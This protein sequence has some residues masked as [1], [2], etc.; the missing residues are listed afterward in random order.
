MREAPPFSK[1]FYP[2]SIAV[3]GVSPEGAN[4]ARNIVL[5]T[6]TCGFKGEVFSV[7]RTQ[8]V[9]FGQKI[10]SSVEEIDREIDLAVILT[11]A[12]TIPGI[13]EQ[14]GRKGIKAAV[15]E[16]GGF[17]EFDAEGKALEQACTAAAEKYGIR[18]VGPNGIGVTNLESGLAL[19]FMPLRRDLCLGPV[20]ILAQ[21]GGVGLSYVN[22]LSDERIGFNKFVSM[23]NKRNINENELMEYLIHDPGTK[24]ILI[25]LEGFSDGRKFVEV[26]SRSE[27][28]ILVHKSNRFETSAQIAHSHTTAMF[29]NDRLVEHALRQ[30]GCVRVDTMDE[31][32][33]YIRSLS[34]PPLKGKRLAVVSRSG[35]HAVIAADACGYYGF[36]LPEFPEEMLQRIRKHV[37]AGVI[38]LQNPLDLGDMFDLEFYAYIIEELLKKEDLDGVLLGHGYRKGH[39]EQ[40][41]RALLQQVVR[42]VEKYQKPVAAFV[43]TEASE[44]EYFRHNVRIPIFDSPEDAMRAFHLSHEWSS[45]RPLPLLKTGLDRV[46]EDRAGKIL[47]EADGE[48]SLLLSQSIELIKSYGF[49]VARHELAGTA[50]EAVRIW[51]SWNS[52][53]ALKVNRPHL[54]HKSDQGA[55]KLDLQSEDEIRSAFEE[56]Q[57]I[58]GADLEVL[59]QEMTPKGR[60]IILGGKRDDCFGPVVLFGL[61]GIFV[62]VFRDAVW[63]L[64]PVRHEEA[65]RMIRSI[66][67]ARV[68]SGYRGERPRDLEALKDLLVRLS[69]MLVTFPQIRE[70]DINPVIVMAEGEGAL[71]VDA[72]VILK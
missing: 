51:R 3:F 66:Q 16:S 30:A 6:L 61:G 41:S 42:L 29:T 46:D 15:I 71:A 33:H 55:V 40:P 39:E 56:L 12:K 35:G 21:S 17:S 59:V 4:L 47:R 53:L 54:S 2:R 67:G 9:A 64:A 13:L 57:E 49:A 31:A 5:N 44:K 45:R 18:F 63:R 58:G 1:L 27:K 24:I 20:S 72:R 32:I 7:G 23:G 22:F 70:I 10:Y 8:G 65:A 25:Y 14:C 34:L 69:Q 19:P 11:P 52:P 28:P 26:A 62:E 43:M 68:L 48:E 38:R 50:E 36:D 37:R 60:E